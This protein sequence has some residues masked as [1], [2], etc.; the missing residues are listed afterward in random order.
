MSLHKHLATA[1]ALTAQLSGLR[2]RNSGHVF[3]TNWFT[4]WQGVVR[5]SSNGIMAA[6]CGHTLHRAA[7]NAPEL[8]ALPN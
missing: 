7:A 5:G 6:L 4:D 2:M 8:L 1:V 3:V